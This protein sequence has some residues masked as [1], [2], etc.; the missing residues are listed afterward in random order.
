MNVEFQAS[1]FHSVLSPLS[2]GSSVPLHFLP[3]EWSGI[4]C[5]SEV[6]DMSPSNVDSRL[7]FIQPG[8]LDDGLY[9]KVKEAG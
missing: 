6:V 5:I 2:E 8:I 3:L 4:I 1:F 7:Y 9:V